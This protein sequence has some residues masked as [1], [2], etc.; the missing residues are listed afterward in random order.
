M[1]NKRT[2]SDALCIYRDPPRKYP[3]L[4][5]IKISNE[6]RVFILCIPVP[7]FLTALREGIA[8]AAWFVLWMCALVIFVEGRIDWWAVGLCRV[9]RRNSRQDRDRRG[10]LCVL[11]FESRCWD[12]RFD[13]TAK[14]WSWR[15]CAEIVRRLREYLGTLPASGAKNSST[16]TKRLTILYH[17]H[18]QSFWYNVLYYNSWISRLHWNSRS[19][20]KI[21]GRRLS[22][23]RPTWLTPN[24]LTI[25][26]DY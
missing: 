9:S 23:A 11:S 14:Q 5:T 25:C 13:R 17:F 20:L 7:S 1:N 24:Q 18:K 3:P 2:P 16:I 26:S 10:M 12:G 8:W 22:A 19:K 6:F 4:Q 21:E 15:A